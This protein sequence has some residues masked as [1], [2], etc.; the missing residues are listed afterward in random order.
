MLFYWTRG[1]ISKILN[2][3]SNFLGI[4]RS[5]LGATKWKWEFLVFSLMA[6]SSM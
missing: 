3:H 5:L 1:N 4:N 2:M 6:F